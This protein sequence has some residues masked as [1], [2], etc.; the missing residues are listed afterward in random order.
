MVIAVGVTGWGL[1]QWMSPSTTHTPTVVATPHT[2]MSPTP[3]GNPTAIAV[4]P[5]AVT[6]VEIRIED[7]HNQVTVTSPRTPTQIPPVGL[8]G[9]SR[10][11][12][13]TSTPPVATQVPSPAFGGRTPQSVST[14]MIMPGDTLTSIAHDHG[15]TLTQL[16]TVNQLAN[17]NLIYAGNTL[18]VPQPT[19]SQEREDVK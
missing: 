3:S 10:A 7:E 13:P 19:S 9:Q 14:I 17:P 15:V 16:M 8:P 6:T 5:D 4:K 11:S 18:L 12:Q 2:T 1:I